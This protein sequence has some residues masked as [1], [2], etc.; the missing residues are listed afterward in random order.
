MSLLDRFLFVYRVIGDLICMSVLGCLVS[1]TPSRCDPL[2]V[3]F[4]HSFSFFILPFHNLLT[5]HNP[6]VFPSLSPSGYSHIRTH[7]HI[8][9]E[10]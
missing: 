10:Y 8:D 1:F 3:T 9:T 6:F 4:C 2:V 5:F 7:A